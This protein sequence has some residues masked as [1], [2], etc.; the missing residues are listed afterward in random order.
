MFWKKKQL[1]HAPVMASTRIATPLV[2]TPAAARAKMPEKIGMEKPVKLPGP[3]EIPGLVQKHLVT[4]YKMAPDL[5]TILKAVVRKNEEEEKR[6]DIRIFDEAESTVKRVTVKNYTTLDE[7]P[8]LIIYEGSVDEQSKLVKLE[9]RKKVNYNV[10]LLSEAEILSRIE[11]LGEPGSSVF[12]YQARGPANGGPL[13]R[14]A[15]LVELNPAFPNKRQKKYILYT[16]N[17][18]G[19]EPVA[20]GKEK[21]MQSNKSKELAKWIKEA[22][23][24]RRY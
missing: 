7:H 17:V 24:E 23:H 19:M 18:D 10:P 9:E 5:A 4:E 14:G 1:I 11:N 15:A 2:M 20:S 3:R 12:F 8:S 16:A 13:G 22:H 6:Y 21:L